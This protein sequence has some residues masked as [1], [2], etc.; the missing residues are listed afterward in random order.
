M[1]FGTVVAVRGSVVDVRFDVSLPSIH[2]VLHA[3][4]GQIVL[5]VLAQRDAHL[6]ARLH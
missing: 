1:N 4:E 3:D 2:T 6:C 5:E